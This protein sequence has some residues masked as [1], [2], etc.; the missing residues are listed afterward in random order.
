M[1]EKTSEGIQARAERIQGRIGDPLDRESAV[2][3]RILARELRKER[4]VLL[5]EIKAK[6]Q[7]YGLQSVSSILDAVAE[8]LV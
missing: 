2:S 7:E 4:K 5:D 8:D 3:V 1:N 6:A